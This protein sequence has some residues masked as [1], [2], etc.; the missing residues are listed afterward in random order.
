MTSPVNI[1]SMAIY[2]IRLTNHFISITFKVGDVLCFDHTFK[3]PQID[4][5]QDTEIVFFKDNA[6][7]IPLYQQ[8]L[9]NANPHTNNQIF[10]SCY[11]N[12]NPASNMLVSY[13][14][15]CSIESIVP[16][17]VDSYVYRYFNSF[18]CKA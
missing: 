17:S 11:N 7:D 10:T 12:L 16:V 18:F 15:K 4:N 14:G 9:S 1:I 2:I 13:I 3:Y 6:C 8:P 5:C